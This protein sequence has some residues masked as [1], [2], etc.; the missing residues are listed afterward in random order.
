MA[1]MLMTFDGTVG[2]A[3]NCDTVEIA[4]CRMLLSS[5]QDVVGLIHI[6]S[7]GLAVLFGRS[8]EFAWNGWVWEIIA[9]NIPKPSIDIN[10]LCVALI[11]MVE[12]G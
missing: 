1:N 10:S 8:T 11:G 5:I 12:Y 2:Q 9:E 7:S 3:I 4:D 6:V